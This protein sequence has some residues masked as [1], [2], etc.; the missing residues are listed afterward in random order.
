M[1]ATTTGPAL[2][3]FPLARRYA[4]A[5][6]RIRRANWSALPPGVLSV[7][8]QHN[9]GG[10]TTIENVL[11][12]TS[13][14]CAWISYVGGLYYITKWSLNAAKKVET[15]TT[16]VAKDD[17]KYED[18]IAE[19]WTLLPPGCA[20]S[21]SE[22]A[23]AGAKVLRGLPG[24]PMPVT[25]SDAFFDFA[26]PNARM[27]LLGCSLPPSDPWGSV[28]GN[29]ACANVG[30]PTTSTDPGTGDPRTNGSGG[31]G[32]G[33]GGSGGSGG[34]GGGGSPPNNPGGS[35]G[36]G[37]GSGGSGHNRP[38]RPPKVPSG[39]SVAVSVNRT[40][41]ECYQRSDYTAGANGGTNVTNS[42]NG[43][44]TLSA[45]DDGSL[46]WYKVKFRGEIKQSGNC[47]AGDTIGWGGFDVSDGQ[48]GASYP[49]VVD[50]HKPGSVPDDASGSGTAQ[51]PD[52]CDP[53]LR[54]PRPPRPPRRPPLPPRRPP[55]RPPRPPRRP[56]RPPREPRRPTDPPVR[57]GGDNYV[58][59]A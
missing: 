38:Q 41:N 31:S 33:S 1:S 29:C 26:A 14:P 52:W 11:S 45:T 39:S 57:S 46:W 10:T 34:N 5:G 35:G 37:G 24:Y 25:S 44:F 48:P 32:G 47:K 43:N 8:E 18:M 22:C 16:V 13:Q 9:A 19:D 15:K 55:R 36:G 58:P 51:M 4:I 59:P 12:Y 2:M 42:F 17:F 54:P 6:W 40:R 56:P 23:C 28:D 7:T 49:V 3:H 27:G 50:C 21:D 53:R 20:T 30:T